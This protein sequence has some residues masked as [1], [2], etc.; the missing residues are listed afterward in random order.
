MEYTREEIIALIEQNKLE[1]AIDKLIAFAQV[2]ALIKRH[3]RWL[4]GDSIA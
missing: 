2:I 3:E 4:I 1:N